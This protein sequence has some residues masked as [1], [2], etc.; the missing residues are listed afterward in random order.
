[1]K[2]GSEPRAKGVAVGMTGSEIGLAGVPPLE[3]VKVFETNIYG[4]WHRGG[5]PIQHHG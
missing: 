3:L 4:M 2:M 5:I 1:M